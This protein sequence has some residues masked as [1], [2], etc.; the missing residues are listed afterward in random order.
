MIPVKGGVVTSYGYK[1]DSTPD[2]NSSA[3]I[4]AFTKHLIP[5]KSFGTTY[6][7]EKQFR[8][9]GI[10]PGDTVN[11]QL[12]NGE[13]VTKIWHDRGAT[14]EQAKA[15]KLK[16]YAGRFDFYSPNG[17]D[18]RSGLAVVGFSKAENS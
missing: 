3:G 14:P 12:S 10:Q 8:E 2:A 4:G 17:A 7:V 15:K 9:N 16:N 1:G 11:L 6:D 5:G 18:K 13:V